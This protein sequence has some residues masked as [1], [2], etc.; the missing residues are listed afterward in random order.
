[1]NSISDK[2]TNKLVSRNWTEKSQV[3]E[4]PCALAAWASMSL[5]LASPMQY[6]LGT[7]II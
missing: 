6:K 7:Y 2:Y 4:I 3:P 5:P 1:M